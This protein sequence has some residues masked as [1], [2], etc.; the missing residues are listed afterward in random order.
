MTGTLTSFVE[1]RFTGHHDAP[2]AQRMHAHHWRVRFH[3]R[4]PVTA[5]GRTILAEVRQALTPLH[6]AGLAETLGMEATNEGIALWLAKTLPHLV[7][8]K[9]EVW[10]DED[11]L[12][13]ILEMN[14]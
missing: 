12:G 10:R 6:Q 11:H 8:V 7:P 1:A 5:D 13:A 3:Y 2:F 14:L 9:I 4:R